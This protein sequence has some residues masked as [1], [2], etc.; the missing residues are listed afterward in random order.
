MHTRKFTIQFEFSSSSAYGAPHYRKMIVRAANARE[1]ENIA[2]MQRGSVWGAMG[3]DNAL[4]CCVVG[5]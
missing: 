3:T 4:D 2:W 1:A 5:E